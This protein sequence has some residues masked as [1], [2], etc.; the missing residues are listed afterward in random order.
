MVRDE[1]VPIQ[2]VDIR[3]TLVLY[4]GVSLA[5]YMAGVTEE[6]YNLV[7]ATALCDPTDISDPSFMVD[8]PTAVQQLYRELAS[9]AAGHGRRLRF[10]ID[11]VS[12]TS[13][14]GINGVL[15]AHALANGKAV[16]GLRDLW[17]N[18]AD[19]GM[20]GSPKSWV[21]PLDG[22]RVLTEAFGALDEQRKSD[23]YSGPLVDQIDLYVTATDLDGVRRRLRLGQS[24]D[25]A[26]REHRH[27]FHFAM[28]R[29]GSTGADLNEFDADNGAIAAL[30]F[31][32]RC[33][34]A[35]PV[36]FWPASWGDACEV[37]KRGHGSADLEK[38]R[39]LLDLEE[40]RDDQYFTDGG[41][42]DNR[43]FNDALDSL[44]RR[45]SAASVKRWLVVVD[46]ERNL[47]AEA[48]ASPERCG[49]T[50][51]YFRDLWDAAYTIPQQQ[52]IRAQ[53]AR[54]EARNKAIMEMFALHRGFM[55]QLHDHR[56]RYD[57]AL[58][59][60]HAARLACEPTVAR[61]ELWQDTW[62]N[63][64]VQARGAGY[65]VYHRLKAERT[66]DHLAVCLRS[67]A[68]LPD[69]A[70]GLT[71]ARQLM[72]RWASALFSE[73][74]PGAS[75]TDPP[76][77][78]VPPETRE[79]S[80]PPWTQNRLLYQFDLEYRLR[81]LLHLLEQVDAA[82][83]ED[84]RIAAPVVGLKRELFESY[85]KLRHA[86]RTLR[87]SPVHSELVS[88]LR[89]AEEAARAGDE[90]GRNCIEVQAVDEFM[91]AVRVS[92]QQ[93]AREE[94]EGWAA[95][96][97]LAPQVASRPEVL[98]L[99]DRI[100]TAREMF[101]F[102][103]EVFF[104]YQESNNLG[105][106]V[107]M[108]VVRINPGGTPRKL[109]GWDLSHFGGFFSRPGRERDY[110]WGR[111]DAAEILVREIAGVADVAAA[112][113]EATLLTT[114]YCG[115]LR[116]SI[117]AEECP[118]LDYASFVNSPALPRIG[119]RHVL[120]VVL[121]RLIT[122]FPRQVCTFLERQ[123]H[124]VAT[125]LLF[126]LVLT[127]LCSAAFDTCR[128]VPK[129]AM[130]YLALANDAPQV[131]GKLGQPVVHNLL[132][133]LGVDSVFICC[134]V[135]FLVVTAGIFLAPL[136]WPPTPPT[137]GSSAG[138]GA[139]A[140]TFAKVLAAASCL[141]IVVAGLCDFFGENHALVT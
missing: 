72:A 61:S 110:V 107:P 98:D 1:S 131:A 139:R 127:S 24:D 14:G 58:R 49:S 11:I 111:L 69:D 125:M 83:V 96:L 70:E 53:I 62:L 9:H 114:D 33:T 6:L 124:A 104:L 80:C 103:D 88:A 31:A 89:G 128:G 39:G 75:A 57:E 135:P 43:P 121:R 84:P 7:A 19:L 97:A 2:V 37:L 101:R 44:G 130:L 109:L 34:S 106:V 56:K 55:E 17:L 74:P 25:L 52:P 68:G 29:V 119:K 99:Y 105:D 141:L 126:G 38:A 22:D 28:G 94:R 120:A 93:A 65:M 115:K 48:S 42:L 77:A 10:V 54:V 71:T 47:E 122:V 118:S 60:T 138:I 45:R 132:I 3:L 117:V 13:A 66:L 116:N 21:L 4:G 129:N 15:L 35:H 73:N 91:E 36:A 40:G 67:A 18:L 86:G 26:E 134:Y 79:W 51:T 136:A 100:R 76:V 20:L 23:G 78:Y 64:M 82:V 95:A 85:T 102:Y 113:T 46:P 41:V 81:R 140:R 27:S 8:K 63:Q 112:K 92:L 30:A 59:G 90:E 5:V 32:A 137:G 50:W 87:H 133:Q 12:G 123:R 16:D 108:D